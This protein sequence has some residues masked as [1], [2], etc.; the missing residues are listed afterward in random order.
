MEEIRTL[1][2]RLLDQEALNKD[3]VITSLSAKVKAFEAEIHED[4][5]AYEFALDQECPRE[6]YF[7]L[8]R[9]LNVLNA[10]K[11]QKALEIYY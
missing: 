1:A 8:V 5:Y 6:A 4:E 9:A 11:A 10:I 2:G 3:T 7:F